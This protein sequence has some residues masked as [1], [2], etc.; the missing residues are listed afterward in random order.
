MSLRVHISWFALLCAPTLA[1]AGEAMM[2]S[3]HDLYGGEFG[4]RT[5]AE[6]SAVCRSARN[7]QDETGDETI[8]FMFGEQQFFAFPMTAALAAELWDAPDSQKPDSDIDMRLVDC[9]SKTMKRT[10]A[11]SAGVFIAELKQRVYQRGS[12]L[13][14]D[15]D[16]RAEGRF[17]S[18]QYARF[19]AGR[20]NS[21]MN[22]LGDLFACACAAIATDEFAAI[23]E[24][25]RSEP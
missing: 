13:G 25:L 2:G 7:I 17:L 3:M 24:Q 11:E 22:D 12:Q 8:L 20:D 18:E 1:I 5:S 19:D 16:F 14:D 9:A 23:L 10:S 21:V 4:I 6:D 15:Y